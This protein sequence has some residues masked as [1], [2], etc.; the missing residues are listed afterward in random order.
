MAVTLT[1]PTN[2]AKKV[3]YQIVLA[4]DT[5]AQ[6]IS[7]KGANRF[8]LDVKGITS[9]EVKLYFTNSA[10]TPPAAGDW[11]QWFD[12]LGANPWD[13]NELGQGSAD[14]VQLKVVRDGSA[15]G[16]LT[17]TLCLTAI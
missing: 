5:D 4:A 3:C 1:Q 13:G 17:A 16:D 10:A 15:D 7:C 2:T 14:F 11:K 12:S 8:S 6:I 9:D